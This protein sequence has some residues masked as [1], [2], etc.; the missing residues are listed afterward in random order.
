MSSF[1]AFSQVLTF[2]RPSR[3]AEMEDLAASQVVPLPHTV[4]A[5]N[6]HS[7]QGQKEAMVKEDF[8][9]GDVLRTVAGHEE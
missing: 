6:C 1:V 2:V 9:R 7:P 4:I 8:G 3:S 5:I